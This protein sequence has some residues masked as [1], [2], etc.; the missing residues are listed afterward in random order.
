[1][2]TTYSR[3]ADDGFA[4]LLGDSGEGMFLISR[5]LEAATAM[6][7]GLGVIYGTD[8][9][10][11]FDRF[12]GAGV[13]AGIVAHKQNRSQPALATTLGIVQ[14]EVASLV[15]NGRIWVVVEEAITVGDLVFV[16]H[17]AGGG[18]T[19]LGAWR[20]DADTASAQ[21]VPEA[22]WLKGSTGAGIALLQINLP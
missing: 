16:R 7:F 4:G 6:A 12:A 21:A 3:V 11:Q 9:E 1:M 10:K 22:S 5:A 15:R 19:Q 8:P 18:G 17:T 20:N 2:Q 14:N 13:L